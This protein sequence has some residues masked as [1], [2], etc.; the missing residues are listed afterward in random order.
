MPAPNERITHISR[1]YL[2]KLKELK[3]LKHH[4]HV[5]LAGSHIFIRAWQQVEGRECRGQM[6]RTE[7]LAP[8]RV[9]VLH[10]QR[11]NRTDGK[12]G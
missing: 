9:W 7:A 12:E 6:R 4:L 5:A 2:K 1:L 10:G 11:P 3:K 8:A